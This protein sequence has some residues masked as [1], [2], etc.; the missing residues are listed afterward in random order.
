M[1]KMLVSDY[2]QTFYL[3]DQDIE[4]NKIYVNE[5]MDAGNIFVIATGRSYFDF[6]NKLDIYKFKLNFVILN[7][8]AT[9]IDR[10]DKML[11]NISI[12][13]EIIPQIQ[14]DLD[15]DKSIN[16][17]CC[18]GIE[19]RVNFKHDDLTKINVRYN[20][21]DFALDKAKYI[22]DKYGNYVKAYYVNQNSIEIISNKTNKSEAIYWLIRYCQNI[23]KTDVYTIGDG[24]S[25]IEMVKEFNGY[26]MKDSIIDL[27]KISN[28]EYNSVSDLIKDIL[29]GEK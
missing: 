8:G 3:S 11:F 26:C 24:Y 14:N 27:K 17:F 7:H 13:N 4:I 12:P 29:N 5:F 25:D 6:H 20:S 15:L 2:D 10:N 22:N 19:S 16:S 28:N 18:S 23:N 9:I 1:S 21:E